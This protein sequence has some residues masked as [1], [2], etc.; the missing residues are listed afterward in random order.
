MKQDQSQRDLRSFFTPT[1]ST[2]QSNWSS[3]KNEQRSE[4]GKVIQNETTGVE[5]IP[6]LVIDDDDLSV[7]DDVDDDTLM[8]GTCTV[9]RGGGVVHIMI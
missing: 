2:L 7:W 8:S 3:K 6:V 9:Y 4:K 5:P 1:S